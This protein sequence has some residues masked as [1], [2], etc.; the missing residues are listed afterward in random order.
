MPRKP[1]HEHEFYDDI[2]LMMDDPLA[3]AERNKA[4][5]AAYEKARAKREMRREIIAVILVI[6]GI[7]IIV[8]LFL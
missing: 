8:S 7:G 1:E 4:E 5:I 2:G 6:T 3:W